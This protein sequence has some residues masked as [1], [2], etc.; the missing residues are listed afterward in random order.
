MMV[1]DS[2]ARRV[3]RVRIQRKIEG[4]SSVIEEEDEC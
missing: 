3:L 1:L 4:V 2:N